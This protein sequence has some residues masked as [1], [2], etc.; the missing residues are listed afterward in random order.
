MVKH[1]SVMSVSKAYQESLFPRSVQMQSLKRISHLSHLSD[2]YCV[3][4]VI[5]ILW[6]HYCGLYKPRYNHTSA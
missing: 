5:V 6:F 1:H 2:M 3:N 4:R